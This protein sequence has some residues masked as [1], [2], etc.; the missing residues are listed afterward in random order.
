MLV[1]CLNCGAKSPEGS[2]E[3]VVCG[4]DLEDRTGDDTQTFVSTP[5]RE[6]LFGRYEVLGE[7][8][9]G[10]MG[11]VLRVRDREIA[12]EVALKTLAPELAEDAKGLER[13]RNELKLARK[14]SHRNVCRLYA[15]G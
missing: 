10:G 13:F 1:E 9:R 8:G 2:S 4:D 12:E 5:T 15:L 7:A 11:R 3:C 14:I 6:V